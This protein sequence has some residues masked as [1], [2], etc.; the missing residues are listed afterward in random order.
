MLLTGSFIALSLFIA[1]HLVAKWRGVPSWNDFRK[2]IACV[3]FTTEKLGS[4]EAAL[5]DQFTEHLHKKYRLAFASPTYIVFL[6][7]SS[8]RHW[9]YFYGLKLSVTDQGGTIVEA[10]IE[11]RFVPTGFDSKNFSRFSKKLEFFVENLNKAAELEG[12]E[13]EISQNLKVK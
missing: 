9:G 10:H 5:R 1:S 3:Y 4:V 13:T 7:K 2:E 8:W 6:E 11:P 12:S